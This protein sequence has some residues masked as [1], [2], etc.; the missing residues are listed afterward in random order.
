VPNLPLVTNTASP[1]QTISDI[2]E[3]MKI[4][5]GQFIM[6]CSSG[7]DDAIGGC[8][9]NEF[10]AHKVDIKAFELGKY[11]VTVGQFKRFTEETSYLT[12]AEKNQQ[13]CTIADP[14]HQGNWI[15]DKTKNWR[16]PG[17]AQTANHPVV[18]ISWMDI[19]T[20]IE[21]LNQKT[22]QH[23]RLPTEEEWEYAARGGKVTAFYWG[24]QPSHNFANSQGKE[25]ADHWEFTSPVGQFA[26]NGFGLHDMAGNVWEWTDSCWKP[27]YQPAN[28]SNQQ[29][30][31]NTDSLKVRR[32]GGWDNLPPSIRAAY[33]SYGSALERSYLYGFRIA[34]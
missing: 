4:P 3:M 13:G 23:Y 5:A 14:Q 6:G 24:S 12:T 8:R 25:G 2:P 22:Q 33:R 30:C 32:G 18:C 16:N 20:Y 11:E 27:D 31:N 21:W 19:K 17:F 1:P 10:P 28:Q 15:I 7:W 26:G 9:D 29:D 34:R